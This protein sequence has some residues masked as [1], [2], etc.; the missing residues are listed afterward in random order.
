MPDNPPDLAGAIHDERRLEDRY[1]VHWP[2][3]MSWTTPAGLFV[4]HGRTLNLSFGGAHVAVDRNFAI[5]DKVACRLSVQPWHGNSSMLDIDLFAKVVHA[6][7]SSRAGG[8][9][10]GLQ[11]ES[12]S[13]D[14]KEKLGR[15]VQ[16]LQKGVAVASSQIIHSSH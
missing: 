1:L 3:L 5:G 8:F 15:V 10:I 2:I 11:F 12:F 9:D 7:Y 6:N 16:A 13:G 14:G 4:A